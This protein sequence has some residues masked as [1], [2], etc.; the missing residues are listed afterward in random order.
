MI[1]DRCHRVLIGLWLLASEDAEKNGNLPSIPDIAFRLRLNEEEIIEA[2]QGL[3]EFIEDLDIN[4]ISTRYHLVPSEGETEGETEG[5]GETES[6]P[7]A[8]KQHS[9][10]DGKIVVPVHKKKPRCPHSEIISEYHQIL[11]ML[12]TVREWTTARKAKLRQRWIEKEKRQ[13]VD[14]WRKY[15]TYIAKSKF[16]TG[17]AESGRRPFSQG[18]E[19]F[20]KPENMAKVIEGNYHD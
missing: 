8:D 4:V 13:T 20:L 16:L 15:F 9:D 3:N 12:P 19:W 1:S 2:I 11:P 7:T 14:W 10:D 18:L 17:Q 5:E 6:Q